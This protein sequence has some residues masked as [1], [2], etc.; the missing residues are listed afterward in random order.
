V[1][2]EDCYPYTAGTNSSEIVTPPCL[3]RCTYNT[4][5]SWA[6]DKHLGASAYSVSGEKNMMN[7]IF[8]NGPAECVF[9][10]YNDFMSYTSG[11]Y[12][13][14]TGAQL[15]GHAVKM[16]GWGVENGM[17]Y[18]LC[19]NSWNTSWGDKG[20]FKIRKGTNEC[21]IESAIYAG[22]PK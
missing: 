18:W 21:G 11:V 19:A 1:V 22:L 10:V 17:K 7:E 3:R 16:L 4:S 9:T 5:K 20:Y 8:T 2:S 6:T 14:V 12:Y 13:H 15:G